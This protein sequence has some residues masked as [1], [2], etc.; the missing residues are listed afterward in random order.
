MRLG[1]DANHGQAKA[2]ALGA[3]AVIHVTPEWLEGV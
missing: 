3:A 1:D 2:A